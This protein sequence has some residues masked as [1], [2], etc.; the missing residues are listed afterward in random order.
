MARQGGNVAIRTLLPLSATTTRIGGTGYE[1]WVNHINYPPSGTIDTVHATPGKWRLEVIP[2]LVTDSLVFLHTIKIGDSINP[3]VAGGAGQI[4]SFSIGVDWDDILY[5][6]NAKGDTGTDYHLMTHIHG[7]RSIGIM[8]ED[9]KPSAE[10]D[11]LVDQAV[12]A[13]AETDRNGILKLPDGFLPPGDH[14]IEIELKS[15]PFQ[16]PG[17]GKLI[18]GLIVAYPNPARETLILEITSQ[19]NQ[20][21]DFTFYNASGS[22]IISGKIKG[23][24]EISTRYL[25]SGT[26]W[27]EAH[28]SGQR[29]IVKILI[30]H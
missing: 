20:V 13:S 2:G 25:A 23:K 10:F 26:Y 15:S 7:G 8:A 21:V 22:R 18:S 12:I 11:V 3:S 30:V 14:V 6:F 16:V 24:K 27:I 4:N 17:Q 9:L 19:T 1:F 28:D 29:E 5:F